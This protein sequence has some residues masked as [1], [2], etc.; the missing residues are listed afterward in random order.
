MKEFKLGNGY[1]DPMYQLDIE[2]K[3]LSE[4]MDKY[5]KSL[6][7]LNESMSKFNEKLKELN[8]P[9]KIEEDGR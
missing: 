3:R 6:E 7:Q 8:T 2:M 1:T 5:I 9:L 4:T